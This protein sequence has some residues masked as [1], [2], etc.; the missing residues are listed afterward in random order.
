MSWPNRPKHG[1]KGTAHYN[2][3]C[4][5]VA[6]CHNPNVW[7]YKYYG[8]RGIKVC[9]RWRKYENF[10]ADMGMCPEGHFIERINNNGDYEPNNC[11]WATREE[12]QK[13]TR[14]NQYITFNGKTMMQSEWAK[15]LGITQ[16]HLHYYLNRNAFEKAYVRFNKEGN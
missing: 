13:N 16:A 10:L 15:F 9:D 6:R 8:G 3:W 7:N 14:Q 1:M 4:A 5:M 11:K 2:R 12:Q